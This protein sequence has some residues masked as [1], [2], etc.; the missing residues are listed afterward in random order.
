MDTQNQHRRVQYLWC[1][2]PTIFFVSLEV[3]TRN[4]LPDKNSSTSLTVEGVSALVQSVC[5]DEDV[6]FRW[7]FVSI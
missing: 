6:V 5:S 1:V 4:T 2:M 7:I 3:A